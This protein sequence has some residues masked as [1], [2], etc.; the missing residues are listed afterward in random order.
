MMSEYWGDPSQTGE[1]LRDGLL[2]TRD[3]GRLRRTPDLGMLARSVRARL[4]AAC[5][6]QMITVISEAPVAPSGKFDKRALL[7]ALPDRRNR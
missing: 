7:S 2:R 3:L 1:A 6:P 5:V 4:G